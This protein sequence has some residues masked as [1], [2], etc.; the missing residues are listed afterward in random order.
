MRP[1]RN[2]AATPRA[3]ALAFEDLCYLAASL[4]G[5]RPA[6]VV[7]HSHPDAA[8]WSAAD[9]GGARLGLDRPAWPLD[10]LLVTLRAGVPREATLYRF[11]ARAGRF[12]CASIWPAPAR[13]GIDPV[14]AREA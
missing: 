6:R 4:D 14:D 13:S 9:E 8:A 10:H 1:C 11:D 12:I 5:P 2:A 7:Y 3:Y